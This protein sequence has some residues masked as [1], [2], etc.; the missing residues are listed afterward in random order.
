MIRGTKAHCVIKPNHQTIY[1][2]VDYDSLIQVDK[3]RALHPIKRESKEASLN[4]D[5]HD[6]IIDM[7]RRQGL[8]VVPVKLPYGAF[9]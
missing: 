3:K 5:Y 1:K 8:A 9:I 7:N 4:N 2:M 6:N